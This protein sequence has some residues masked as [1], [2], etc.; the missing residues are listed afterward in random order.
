MDQIGWDR[1]GISPHDLV[2]ALNLQKLFS[3]SSSSSSSTDQRVN[4]S[5]WREKKKQKKGLGVSCA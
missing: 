4:L 5:T 3:S 2:P 1:S